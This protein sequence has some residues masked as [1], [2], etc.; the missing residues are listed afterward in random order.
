MTRRALPIAFVLGLLAVV[1]L[2]AVLL[3]S[4]TNNAGASVT[5][6]SSQA[7]PIPAAALAAHGQNITPLNEV[8]PGLVSPDTAAA[9]ALKNAPPGSQILKSELASV[10][11]TPGH[12]VCLCYVVA[13]NPKG[14]AYSTAGGLGA[15]H[16]IVSYNYDIH[17]VDAKTGSGIMASRGVDPALGSFPPID[18]VQ[19]P[20]GGTRVD[21]PASN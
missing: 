13:V 15:N 18:G 17:F 16:G 20:P 1:V 2:A 19:A 8:P 12:D 14:G 9:A 3:R 4:T 21:Q 11:N 6:T 10:T 7:D 5:P